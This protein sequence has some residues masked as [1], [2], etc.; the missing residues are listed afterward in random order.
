MAGSGRKESREMGRT[1]G[2]REMGRVCWLKWDQERA[3]E[4]RIATA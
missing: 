2:R 4:V 1:R 3:L